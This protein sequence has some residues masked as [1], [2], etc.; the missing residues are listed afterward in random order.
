MSIRSFAAGE[1]IYTQEDPCD[2]AFVVIS[3]EVEL[4]HNGHRHIVKTGGIFGKPE[5]IET[6]PHHEKAMAKS[7]VSAEL[8]PGH[9]IEKH[10]QDSHKSAAAD[11]SQAILGVMQGL[12]RITQQIEQRCEL[13]E[14]KLQRLS[15]E[16]SDDN[17][18]VQLALT[19]ELIKKLSSLGP[20]TP[21]MEDET[22]NDILINGPGN[23]YVERKGLLEKTDI[24]F[25]DDSEVLA[26]ADK[27]VKIVGRR[28]DAK[29]PLVDAR[30]MDGSRVNIIAPPLAVDGTSISIR[31]FSKKKITLDLMKESKNIN[32]SLGEFLK[33]VGRCRL[34]VIISG[35]TGSGKT[36]LLNALSQYIDPAERIVTIEDAAE[37]QLQQPHVIRLETRPY[38]MG[39]PTAEIVTMRDLLKNALRMRPDRIL[40]GEVRGA[41][42]F[43]MMQAMNTGHEGSLTTMHANHPRDAL[44]RMENM[45]SMADLHIPMKS[46]RYQIASSMHLIVQI[47]RMRDGHRRVTH[48][49]EIVGMEGEIITMHDLFNFIPT[50]EDSNGNVLGDFKW[51]GIMPRF[52]K[53]VAYYGDLPRLEAALGMKLQKTL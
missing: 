37:L 13:M 20:I 52:V 32:A 19:Q 48:V 4:S 27:I 6:M 21:L 9:Q 42:A 14:R 8:I 17:S 26:I 25:K 10:L 50:G 53:R 47:S 1:V 28:L 15:A 51:S 16:P 49:S 2:S 35:G 40:V 44:A 31:K 11:P 33:V 22:I 36:T 29:R 41:E 5:L 3:G 7:E 39:M 34:N 30:L 38:Y 43:D 12:A 46:L 18:S 23:V 24:T 45:V